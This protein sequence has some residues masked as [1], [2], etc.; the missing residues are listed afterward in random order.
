MGRLTERVGRR[1]EYLVASILAQV[2]DTVLI[3]P[4]GAEADIV[5]EYRKKLYKCQV[6]TKTKKE[7]GHRKWRF[8][9]RRGSHTKKRHFR[10][11]ALDLY[12]MCSL[13]HNNVIFLPFVPGKN[14]VRISD[15]EMKSID[16]LE[17]LRES[18]KSLAD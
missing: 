18:I 15:E 10:K 2:S 6:K 17:S 11:G 3:V 9:L 8:D 7:K 14:E 1:G 5:F 12:A 13:Q 4:H 16:S